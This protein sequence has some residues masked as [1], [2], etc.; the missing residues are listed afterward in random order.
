MTQDS[1]DTSKDTLRSRFPFMWERNVP[2]GGLAG[3]AYARSN[4]DGTVTVF[5]FDPAAGGEVEQTFSDA[6][7][8]LIRPGSS[9]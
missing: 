2:G 3:G 5:I 7:V 6:G 4:G 8:L 1:N 9:N